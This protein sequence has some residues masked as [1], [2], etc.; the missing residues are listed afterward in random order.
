MMILIVRHFAKERE[1][2]A[3]LNAHPYLLLRD[4]ALQEEDMMIDE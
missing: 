4:K 2:Y 3:E 1:K